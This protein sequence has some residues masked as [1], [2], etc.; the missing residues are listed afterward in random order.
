MEKKKSILLE[1]NIDDE[2]FCFPSTI[3]GAL[4]DANAEL[5][6]LDKRIEETSE[7]VKS[8][9]PCCDKLDY[10]LA[11]SS[12]AL[13]GI[14]DIFLVGNPGESPLGDA[15]DKWF[16]NRTKRFCKAL[17]IQRR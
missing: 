1:M 3:S 2:R 4:I 5:E 15:T 9:T 13:C 17:W 10:I 12:G 11:A 16:A 14:I 7:T 8:L 6:E